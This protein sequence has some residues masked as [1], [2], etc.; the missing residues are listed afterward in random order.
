[1]KGG[2]G[3]VCDAIEN[4]YSESDEMEELLQ[5]QI[6]NQDCYNFRLLN[7]HF[8]CLWCRYVLYCKL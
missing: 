8:S 7:N 1:M 6:T 3:I 5:K 4:V 2:K